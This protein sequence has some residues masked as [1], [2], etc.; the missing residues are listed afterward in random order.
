MGGVKVPWKTPQL[1][2]A[3]VGAIRTDDWRRPE[4]AHIDRGNLR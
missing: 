4:D 3:R 2:D 1:E